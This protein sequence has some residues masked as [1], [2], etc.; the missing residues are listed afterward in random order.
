[1]KTQNLLTTKKC[2]QILAIGMLLF[3]SET[4]FSQDYGKS[5][6]DLS[7]NISAGTIQ[8]GDTLQIRATFVVKSGTYTNCTYTDAVPAGTTYLP[9]TLSILTNEGKVYNSFTDAS[10]DDAG[11]YSAGNITIN[12]GS[13]ATSSAGGTISNTSKPSFY[14]STCILVGSFSVVVNAS[15]SFGTLINIGGG[16]INYKSSGTAMA[17]N[18]P[19]DNILLYQSYGM[20]SNSIG[21]NAITTEYG[22]TF[23]SG[24]AKDR[25]PSNDVPAS[26]TYALFSSTAGSPGDYYYGVSNNTSG[27]TTA[28][29]GYSIVN[30]WAKPDN[31][32][33]PSHRIF[34]Y[35]DI[36]G[37]HT[38][39]SNPLLGNPATDVNS[40]ATGGYM[41][42]IN[43]SY[44]TDTAFL[45]TVT[46]LCPNTYY[47]YSVWIRNMCSKCGCDSNGVGASGAGYIP[48]G[49]GDSSGVHPNIT[50]N[51]NGTDYFTTGD[52]PYSGQWVQK[53]F[54][55]L[56]G[57]TQTSMVI[58][59]HNNAP[60]GGGNDWAMDDIAVSTC[61]PSIAL[62]PN[63]PDTLC[64]GSDDTV[65]YQMT[66]Y[67]NNYTQW[68]IQQSLDS[69][70]TWTLAGNDTTGT[71]SSGNATPVYNASLG[72]YQ[73]TITRYYRLDH[74]HTNVQY[75][76]IVAS[77]A[78]NLGSSGC[79]ETSSSIME[80]VA[81]NCSA[82]LPV[83]FIQFSGL[84]Q[85]G[86]SH[87]SWTTANETEGSNY[88]VEKSTDQNHFETIGTV[89]GDAID[90][91]NANYAFT[92]PTPVSGET[93]YR[94]TMVSGR[95]SVMS[96]TILIS[97]NAIVFNIQSLV[98]PFNSQLNFTLTVPG[99]DQAVMTLYDMFGR[100]IVQQKQS[101]MHG[102]N[103]VHIYNLSHLPAAMYMLKVQYQDQV[104][105][106]QVL[107]SE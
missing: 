96:N 79:S 35:W 15:N 62:V 34:G 64:M 75:R 18:F 82:I 95:F 20:C 38:G 65:R 88:L 30:T 16:A 70:V 94:I 56:T 33:S 32:Q 67:F 107:K 101:V 12:L 92:D 45:D 57:P 11:T 3:I 78:S 106:R 31:S 93:Y 91:M 24:N 97:S 100:Q 2:I 81:V 19:A 80:I 52:I 102:I 61:L 42:V 13:G 99:N 104:L 29:L 21:G 105:A 1:M 17:I 50:F 44:R 39:A 60:G 46:N 22:G 7:R 63:K 26:Y 74:V 4:S 47:Q 66:S 58:S 87:L 23:G 28:A 10:G 59:V 76:I 55:Y 69:G 25:G 85:N 37:D 6:V 68:E 86:Q 90:G 77:S 54:V 53:G 71:A 89:A 40:G 73:Y 72:A 5:F 49:V 98:N 14:G 84:L 48:T 43:A 41:L 51:V 83:N 9:G 8:P 103:S 27:G 36:I